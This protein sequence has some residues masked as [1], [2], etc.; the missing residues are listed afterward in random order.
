MNSIKDKYIQL[1]TL[2]CI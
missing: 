2:L 1:H